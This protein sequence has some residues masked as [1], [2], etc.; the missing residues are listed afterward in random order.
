MNLYERRQI[1]VAI[2]REHAGL[3]ALERNYV[4]I[5]L[6]F[7]V[8]RRHR[9]MRALSGCGKTLR[10]LDGQWLVEAGLARSWAQMPQKTRMLPPRMIEWPRANGWT[11]VA[12]LGAHTF[13]YAIVVSADSESI[14]ADP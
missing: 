12:Q 1:R 9:D 4:H 10:S 8:Q 3:L 7:R 2:K 14:S 11:R 13:G 6:L 5:S